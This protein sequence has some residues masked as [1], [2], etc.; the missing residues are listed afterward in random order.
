MHGSLRVNTV[1]T[2]S[3]LQTQH[4]H[5]VRHKTILII[6]HNEKLKCVNFSSMPTDTV[7]F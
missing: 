1:A 2:C 4:K 6:K 5:E 7:K 3:F